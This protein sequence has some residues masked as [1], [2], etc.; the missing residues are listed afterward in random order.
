MF[1]CLVVSHGTNASHPSPSKSEAR[2][3]IH[4]ARAYVW[5]E[6]TRTRHSIRLSFGFDIDFRITLSPPARSPFFSRLPGQKSSWSG[7]PSPWL[8]QSKNQV[9]PYLT[10]T[11]PTHLTKIRPKPSA[12]RAES[13]LSEL[14]RIKLYQFRRDPTT[15]YTL[16][17]KSSR[18]KWLY[19]CR[20]LGFFHF[21]SPWECTIG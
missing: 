20:F 12:S 8:S 6:E 19:T 21:S 14:L 9:P 17:D 15:P 2:P 4:T 3:E 10:L 13:E 16:R 1:S 7:T 5:I 18:R 11:G